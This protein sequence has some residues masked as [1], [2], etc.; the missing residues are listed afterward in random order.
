[1]PNFVKKKSASMPKRGSPEDVAR[2][3]SE[4]GGIVKTQAETSQTLVEQLKGLNDRITKLED[5]N[6]ERSI[7][8]PG[9]NEGQDKGKYSFGRAI[10]AQIIKDWSIAPYEYDLHKECVKRALTTGTDTL[11]GFMVPMEVSNEL[12]ELLRSKIIIEALGGFFMG[13]L[14]GAPVPI[15][16]QD[17]AATGYFVG[18]GASIPESDQTLGQLLLNPH[19]AAGMTRISNRF[20]MLANPDGE[21]F[22]RKDLT[23]VLA[24]LIDLKGLRGDGANDTPLGIANTPGINSTAVGT[25]GGPITYDLLQEIITAVDASDALDGRLA[26]AFHPHMRRELAQLKDQDNR[27][28]FNWD[29]SLGPKEGTAQSFLGY[30]WRTSTQIPVNLTKGSGTDLTEIYF[31]NWEEVIIGQWGGLQILASQ[32]A[33][34]AFEKNQTLVRVIQLI[35]VALRHAVSFNVMTDAASGN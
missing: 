3:I 15:T 10:L 22:V 23:D 14:T 24:R 19:E 7:S 12:I 29:P 34:T 33:G 5:V 21:A 25:N 31:G 30:P 8:L 17:G 6:R 28:L 26:W 4:L 35:D 18:E 27:P 20:L 2:M 16:R 13:G 11:G 32:E 9:C 1:M